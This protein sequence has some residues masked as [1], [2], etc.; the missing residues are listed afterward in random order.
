[1]ISVVNEK[2]VPAVF[3]ESTVEP[4]I[5]QEVVSAT[6][7]RLG[8]VLYVDSLSPADGPASTYLKLLEHT[9]DTIISGLTTE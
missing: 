2:K 3:C 7:T 6:G 5:Q 8:G 4:R 1:V 9:A